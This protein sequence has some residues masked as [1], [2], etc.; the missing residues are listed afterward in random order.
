MA[1]AGEPGT[2]ASL[3]SRF[4][5]AASRVSVLAS[6]LPR[7]ALLQLYARY[8]Q[9]SIGKC[10]TTKPGLFDFEGKQ[11][12]EAWNALGAMSKEQAMTEY[13]ALVNKLDPQWSE[14]VNLEGNRK[15]TS[16]FG[17]VMSSLYKEEIIREEDKTVFDH[18]KDNEVNRL[19]AALKQDAF[20]INQ[21]DEEGRTLLHW[22]C[23]RGHLETVE[24]LLKRGANVNS[25]D[26]EGQTALHY[27]CGCDFP[28]AVRL[29]LAFGADPS[30][31]DSEGTLPSQLADTAQTAQAL[32]QTG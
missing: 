8:K 16:G 6:S 28:A 12:W 11:K 10:N 21:R 23:D 3:R 24:L 25:Q 30:I 20:D 2:S 7:D 19:A 26:D 13:L 27:A 32:T 4:D 1:D 29:L 15:V 14:Q 5:G 9:A 22:A 31:P 17:P 18:C